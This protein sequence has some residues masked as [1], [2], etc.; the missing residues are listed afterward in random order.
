MLSDKE[1]KLLND[2]AAL[3]QKLAA[4][5]ECYS[6]SVSVRNDGD[7]EVDVLRL[8]GP[9]TLTISGHNSQHGCRTLS[10]LMLF[11]DYK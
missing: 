4:E 5:K 1:K 11:P 3:L 9:R 7:I 8:K 10:T 2:A 6:I